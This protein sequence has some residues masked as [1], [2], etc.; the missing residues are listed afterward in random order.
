[1]DTQHF[2]I[3]ADHVQ[4]DNGTFQQMVTKYEHRIKIPGTEA[5][6]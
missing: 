4:G 5:G 3:T 1:M 2:S 6:R